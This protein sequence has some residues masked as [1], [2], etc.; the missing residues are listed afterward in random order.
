MKK[1]KPTFSF[2]AL[3]LVLPILFFTCSNNDEELLNDNQNR[4]END[5][6]YYM[7]ST[8]PFQKLDFNDYNVLESNPLNESNFRNPHDHAFGHYTRQASPE[9]FYTGGN[10]RF[11]VIENDNNVNGTMKY[12][13]SWDSTGTP[14]DLGVG[15]STSFVEAECIFSNGVDAVIVGI[16]T[17]MIGDTDPAFAVGT[18][19]FFKIKDNG[20]SDGDT[21]D[22]Y[23]PA[24][25]FNPG[26]TIPCEVFN[27]DAPIWSIPFPDFQPTNVA[28]NSDKIVVQ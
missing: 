22:Q 15:T 18:K 26:A 12:T 11:N 9:A 24:V 20:N 10:L 7:T 14:F 28:R 27:L 19:L 5:G 13:R 17:R 1:F 2:P 8:S 3:L 21:T 4:L 25:F 16:I 23:V 6:V